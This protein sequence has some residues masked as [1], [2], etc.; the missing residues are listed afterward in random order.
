[1]RNDMLYVYKTYSN[2]TNTVYET[3]LIVFLGF[4]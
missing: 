1:M 4:V 2:N 3:T